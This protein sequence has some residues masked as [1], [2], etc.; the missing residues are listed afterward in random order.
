MTP[1]LMAKGLMDGR[2]T[3]THTHAPFGARRPWPAVAIQAGERPG[4]QPRIGIQAGRSRP[5]QSSTAGSLASE[6]VKI[7]PEL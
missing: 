1:T 7:L 6:E 2:H 4:R 3:H 5:A